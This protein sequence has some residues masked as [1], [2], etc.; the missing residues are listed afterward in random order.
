MRDF[1]KLLA[2]FLQL[3][4]TYII[5]IIV[6]IILQFIIITV[7]IRMFFVLKLI[8]YQSHYKIIKKSN[9]MTQSIFLQI[10]YDINRKK[11]I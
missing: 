10:K 3:V 2:T 5:S 4:F 11:D 8:F 6:I 9:V 7:H 1:F